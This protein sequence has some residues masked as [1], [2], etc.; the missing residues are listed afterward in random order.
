[1]AEGVAITTVFSILVMIDLV[2]NSLVCLVITINRDMRYFHTIYTT[3]LSFI[4]MFRF[5][6]KCSMHIFPLT[7]RGT[8]T[9]LKLTHKLGAFSLM[10][11]LKWKQYLSF[12]NKQKTTILS[13]SPLTFL[14]WAIL[15]MYAINQG[16]PGVHFHMFYIFMYGLKEYVYQQ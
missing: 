12:S 13:L 10:S 4:S 5:V 15:K 6:R 2:G 9:C 11:N 8:H 7:R 14:Q 1:M 3:S 16:S